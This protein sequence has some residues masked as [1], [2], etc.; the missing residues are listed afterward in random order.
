MRECRHNAAYRV[1]IGDIDLPAYV[2]NGE[3]YIQA[4]L[5]FVFEAFG[6]NVSNFLRDM[7]VRISNPGGTTLSFDDLRR[8]LYRSSVDIES[9]V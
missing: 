4:P 5:G 6:E 2:S 3:L 8:T 9:L 1:T 7:E